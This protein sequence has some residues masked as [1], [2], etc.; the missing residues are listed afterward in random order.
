MSQRSPPTTV[1]EYSLLFWLM[2]M[3]SGKIVG[4]PPPSFFDLLPKPRPLTPAAHSG[5]ARPLPKPKITYDAYMAAKVQP[6]HPAFALRTAGEG[7]NT[8]QLAQYK[9]I[10]NPP[11]VP[12][13]RQRNFTRRL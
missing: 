5:T 12:R 3:T 2:C 1:P 9:L 7:S 13:S 8:T 11:D 10:R 4:D 6:P